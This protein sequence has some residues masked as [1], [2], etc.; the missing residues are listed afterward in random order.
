MSDQKILIRARAPLRVSF[1]GGGTDV[2]PYT[3]E[4]GGAVLSTTIDHYAYVQLEPVDG[5]EITMR[6]RDSG[7]ITQGH[8]HE[9]LEINGSH[10]LAK[11]VVSRLKPSSGF[12]MDMHTDVP[13]GSGLG[14][15][16]T[17]VVSVVS[18]FDHW[19]NLDYSTRQLAEISYEI[20][21]V[22]LGQL[23]GRQDQYAAA[24][25]GFN[26]I[27]FDASGNS[28]IPLR[29][30]R[31]TLN[32]LHYRMVACSLGSVR[33]STEILKDQI[34]RFETGVDDAVDALHQTKRIAYEMRN[35]L[36]SG[37]I[38]LMGELLNEAWTHKKNFSGKVTNPA[39]D[40]V[41]N[42]LLENGAVGGKLLGAG[43][44]GHMLFIA[45]RSRRMDLVQRIGELGLNIVNFAFEYKGATAW[46]VS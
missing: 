35:A 31:H 10:D 46:T 24:Y 20:E 13:W 45:E 22:D 33:I 32:E 28:V 16:S 23:G 37:D 26:F 11:A 9:G 38:D 8:V 36:L 42:D 17:H 43:G 21:R 27:E 2:S 14:S 7:Q 39:I 5:P 3:E 12:N 34:G 40:N 15:S 6:D 30:P 41:Y 18:A 1:A 4:H 25:G 29:V 44:G 19:L